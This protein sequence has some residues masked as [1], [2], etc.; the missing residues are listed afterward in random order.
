[1][2]ATDGVD[3]Q[4][5]V[6][7]ANEII[8]NINEASDDMDC[9]WLSDLVGEVEELTEKFID[10]V[11]SRDIRADRRG[12]GTPRAEVSNAH[13]ILERHL[14]HSDC[15]E[16]SDQSTLRD[17]RNR[18]FGAISGGNYGR[19]RDDL[20]ILMSMYS[21]VV[22]E[23]PPTEG[24]LD[25]TLPDRRVACEMAEDPHDLSNRVQVETGRDWFPTSIS[26]HYDEENDQNV[27]CVL[28]EEVIS[29]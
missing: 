29:Q 14:S 26:T 8:S 21:D 22:D 19:A 2:S 23:R 9:E 3:P 15:I 18:L 16:D 25:P 11:E 12:A 28:L 24:S 7:E 4:E 6:G 17:Q 27:A 1:M 5:I 10:A 20:D 13:V